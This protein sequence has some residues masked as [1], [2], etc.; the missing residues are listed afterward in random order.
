M[1]ATALNPSV[2]KHFMKHLANNRK[3]CYM[4]F[5]GTKE[6]N[7]Q[8]ISS[9]GL[10]VPGRNGVRVANGSSHGVGIYSGMK[11]EVSQSYCNARKMFACAVVDGTGEC[12]DGKKGRFNHKYNG[13]SKEVKHCGNFIVIFN[14]YRVVPLFL[15]EWSI[16]PGGVKPELPRPSKILIKKELKPT[17][18]PLTVA[19][20][21]ISQER[22]ETSKEISK[23]KRWLRNAKR[24]L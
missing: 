17:I 19:R 15:L 6:H 8:S 5:H 23:A 11:F 18:S 1:R 4:S 13:R 21:K 14:E 22:K 3:V 24:E 10:L 2:M 20:T 16:C 9:R 12:F 7:I